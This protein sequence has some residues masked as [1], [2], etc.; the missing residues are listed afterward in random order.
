M[1]QF[2]LWQSVQQ[3]EHNAVCLLS[4]GINSS[5]NSAKFF[6]WLFKVRST[7]LFMH[8]CSDCKL[9]LYHSCRGDS[10]HHSHYHCELLLPSDLGFSASSQKTSQIGDK[11]KTEAKW[12]QKLPHHVCGFCDFCLLLGTSQ[13]HWTGCSHRSHGNGTKSSRM[14][15]HCKLLHGLLQQLP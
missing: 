14:V 11:A 7:H 12:L 8:I 10:L 15:V 2:C 6:C 4:L 5:G 9:L 13:L 3:L 1:S